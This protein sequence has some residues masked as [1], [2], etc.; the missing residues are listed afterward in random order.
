MEHGNARHMITVR[1]GGNNAGEIVSHDDGA[2]DLTPGILQKLK[3]PNSSGGGG[4]IRVCLV[5]RKI[6]LH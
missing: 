6:F 4:R 3:V 1:G 2:L 5:K